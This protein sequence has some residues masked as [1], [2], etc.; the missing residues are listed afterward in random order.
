MLLPAMTDISMPADAAVTVAEAVT[1][2]GGHRHAGEV[3]K[4]LL[5]I[6]SHFS[7]GILS[8]S[9][10]ER[11]G[12]IHAQQPQAGKCTATSMR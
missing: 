2:V 7:C 4:E 11:H 12:V 6:N 9:E 10:N 1:E 3:A 5:S 8:A